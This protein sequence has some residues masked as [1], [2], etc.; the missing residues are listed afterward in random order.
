[1]KID[2]TRK[3][4]PQDAATMATA[5]RLLD[6]LYR[7]KILDQ[8]LYRTIP[9]FDFA[10]TQRRIPLSLALN[11]IRVGQPVRLL[12][13]N[14]P[15]GYHGLHVASEKNGITTNVIL[16]V[17]NSIPYLCSAFTD[18]DDI[19][20]KEWYLDRE[21]IDQATGV[22]GDSVL[23]HALIVIEARDETGVTWRF[24]D[25]EKTS[26]MRL[27]RDF[28]RQLEPGQAY[29]LTSGKHNGWWLW[30]DAQPVH[31]GLAKAA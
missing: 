4:A 26:R 3:P 29:M 12:T 25:S 2:P 16:H 14:R 6:N 31:A 30:L 20:S 15:G 13:T 17:H 18:R 10:L 5:A 1:M 19:R 8:G 21:D 28:L 23:A 11:V 22:G 7:L 9:N 24:A 27:N